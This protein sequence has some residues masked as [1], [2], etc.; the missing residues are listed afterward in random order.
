[1]CHELKKVRLVKTEIRYSREQAE[2][3]CGCAFMNR[4]EK[5]EV[6]SREMGGQIR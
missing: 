4:R 3:Q 1:M 2:G 6:K 5:R